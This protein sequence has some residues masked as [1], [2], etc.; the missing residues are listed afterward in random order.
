MG[1]LGPEEVVFYSQD[2]K[3]KVPIGLAVANNKVSL[4]M[5]VTYKVKLPDHNCKAT[6][7]GIISVTCR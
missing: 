4:V 7:A 2:N 3:A 6:Q 1:F 5:H